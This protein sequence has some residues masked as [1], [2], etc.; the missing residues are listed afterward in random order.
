M[1]SRPCEVLR[2][3]LDDGVSFMALLALHLI[4]VTIETQLVPRVNQMAFRMSSAPFLPY[5][6]FPPHFLI[7]RPKSSTDLKTHCKLISGFP[8]ESL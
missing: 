1:K 4:Q 7:S 6:R 8:A 2:E 5:L 3:L